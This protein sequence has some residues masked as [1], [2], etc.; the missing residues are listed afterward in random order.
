MEIAVKVINEEK[1]LKKEQAKERRRLARE[2]A[3]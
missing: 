1:E 3:K 2:A